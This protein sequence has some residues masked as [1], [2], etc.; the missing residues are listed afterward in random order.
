MTNLLPFALFVRAASS[1]VLSLRDLAS[2]WINCTAD[3]SSMLP[4]GSGNQR[5]LATINNF[6]G[7]VGLVSLSLVELAYVR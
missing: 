5:D 6:W 2:D 1:P 4:P 3:V 7:S